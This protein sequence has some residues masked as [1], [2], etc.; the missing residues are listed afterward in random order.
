MQR[1]LGVESSLLAL[2]DLSLDLV[3]DWLIVERERGVGEFFI[4]SRD[5]YIIITLC[6]L[7]ADG[8]CGISRSYYYD[9]DIYT[10]YAHI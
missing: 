7:R 1:L 6:C 8:Y 3:N 9:R 2:G 10:S 4:F 5:A